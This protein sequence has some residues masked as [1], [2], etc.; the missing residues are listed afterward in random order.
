MDEED[1]IALVSSRICHDLISPIGAISNGVELLS[2]PG[3]QL[4]PEMSLIADSVGAASAKLRFFRIAFG[5]APQGAQIQMGELREIVGANLGG[6]SQAQFHAA[7]TAIP[8][9]HAKALLLSLLCLERNLPL[10]GQSAIDLTGDGF[11]IDTLAPKLRD[12][13]D[14]W[15]LVAEGTSPDTLRPDAVQFPL[16]GTLLKDCSGVLDRE[17]GPDS[18]LIEISGLRP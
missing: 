7:V 15:A 6:R 3:K 4:S 2:A 8:R 10:G 1:L 11:R 16:L 18:I 13:E 5:A 14:L 12:A 17:T 9:L